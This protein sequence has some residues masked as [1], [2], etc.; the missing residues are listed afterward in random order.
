MLSTGGSPFGVAVMPDGRYGFAAVPGG[1]AIDVLQMAKTASGRPVLVRSIPV[2]GAEDR[3]EPVTSIGRHR[4]PERA[5]RRA[6]H[7]RPH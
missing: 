3:G 5:S 4:D 6:E 1:S 7:H 2:A